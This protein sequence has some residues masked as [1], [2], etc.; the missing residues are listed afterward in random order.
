[1]RWQ[2]RHARIEDMVKTILVNLQTFKESVMS[3]LSHLNA[4]LADLQTEVAAIGT[5]MD[6]LFADL[7]A[8]LAGGD[9]AAIDA[10]TSSIEAQVQALK[11]IGTRDTPAAPAP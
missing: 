11:D 2:Y 8:A 3:D 9:Q 7:K 1:M 6:T 5:Q 10:A 4:A